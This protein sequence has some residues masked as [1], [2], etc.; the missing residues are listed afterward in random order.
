MWW[1]VKV[2]RGKLKYKKE[3]QNTK[4]DDQTKHKL[5]GQKFIEIQDSS[6]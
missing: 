4:R 5:N 2:K 1:K 3:Q 6:L